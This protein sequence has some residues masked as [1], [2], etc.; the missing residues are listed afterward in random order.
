MKKFIFLYSTVGKKK[1]AER[2]AKYLLQK[3]LIACANI[4]PIESHYWWQKKIQY[5][6]EYAMILKTM[7]KNNR[8]IEQVIKRIHPYDCPCLVI[9]ELKGGYRPYLDWIE[10]SI[11]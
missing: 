5:D 2:I 1:D 7:A 4:F 6:K 9:L 10:D 8:K 11:K 3:K